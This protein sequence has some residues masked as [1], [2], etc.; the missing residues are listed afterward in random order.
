MGG[1]GGG[2]YFSESGKSPQKI[3][4]IIRSEEE[5]SKNAVFDANISNLIR[6]LLADVNNRD[7]ETIQTHLSTIEDALHKDIEGTIDLRY[8]GSVAKHTYVDG[9]S[10]IDSLAILNNSELANYTPDKVKEYFL[11][12]LK[13]RLPNTEIKVGKLAITLRFT[14]GVEIQVLPALRDA[15][16]IRIASSRRDNEWSH[17]IHPDKFAKALR[18]SNSTLR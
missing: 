18:Y 3:A 8:G 10:D 9:L 7:S 14:S 16:G 13:E 11:N 2:G 6:N 12:C 1:S 5:N 15:T 4:Q 17:L